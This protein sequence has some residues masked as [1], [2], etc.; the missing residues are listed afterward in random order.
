MGAQEPDAN[1]CTAA[2]PVGKFQ[3]SSEHSEEMDQTF[4]A[5]GYIQQDLNEGAQKRKRPECPK[6]IQALEAKGRLGG[7]ERWF[8]PPGT[9]MI[10]KLNP[11][12]FL[13]KGLYVL[14]AFGGQASSKAGIRY[15]WLSQQA[16]ITQ[17]TSTEAPTPIKRDERINADGKAP[18]LKAKL[19][20]TTKHCCYRPKAFTLC[21]S[22][23]QICIKMSS[24][25]TVPH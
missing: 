21:L 19:K 16:L 24:T 3:F 25:P 23:S 15:T 1:D 18:A 12:Y 8:Q 14:A 22:W 6:G 10:Q 7:T 20:G 11:G 5:A 13:V 2:H 9:Y 17:K 4:S